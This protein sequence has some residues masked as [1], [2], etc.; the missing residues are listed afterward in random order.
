MPRT[1]V[2]IGMCLDCSLIFD[3]VVIISTFVEIYL[4]IHKSVLYK[5]LCFRKRSENVFEAKPKLARVG[6]LKE[7]KS[8]LPLDDD[9]PIKQDSTH[10]IEFNPVSGVTFR[11]NRSSDVQIVGRGYGED[12][13]SPADPKMGSYNNK[14]RDRRRLTK[15]L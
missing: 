14:A 9:R 10:Q 6:S 1:S 4:T 11:A 3:I 2:D 13:S 12:S 5:I 7:K 15:G 8:S